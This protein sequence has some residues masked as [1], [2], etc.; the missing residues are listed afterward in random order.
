MLAASE[1]APEAVPELAPAPRS[2]GCETE[3][4]LVEGRPERWAVA[5]EAAA[6][7][8]P[9]PRTRNEG[10]AMTTALVARR[11]TRTTVRSQAQVPLNWLPIFRGARSGPQES[12]FRCSQRQDQPEW[13]SCESISGSQGRRWPVG[14]PGEPGSLVVR[15]VSVT[16]GGLAALDDVSMAVGDGEVVGVI[17]P[18]GAGK[19]TLFNVICG[20]VRPT[21]GTI[22]YR[23]TELRRH[24]PHDL[25]R[26]GIA[27]TLQGVGLWRGLSVAENVMAGAHAQQRADFA[28]AIFGLW[29]SSREQKRI[30]RRSME[31]LEELRISEFAN[32]YPDALP[33]A[34]QKRVALARALVA[35]PTLL[36]LD[37]PASGLSSSETDELREMIGV[38]RGRM[39]VLLV[40]HHMDL[41]MSTCDRLVVLNFGRVIASG[42]PAQVRAD[43][44]VTTAYLGEDVPASADS[45][46]QASRA[47]APDVSQLA[48][49]PRRADGAG[50]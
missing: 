33:Y 3:T 10:T 7:A 9:V 14:D 19:T 11:L 12:E 16:F 22:S 8:A 48:G 43:P 21:E 13:A 18:N 26:L 5:Y 36:M 29:R 46:T 47:A 2:L 39:G 30:R 44:E 34:I 50:G 41:V 24:H 49:G 23:G 20:F 42:P 4:E 6:T 32:W 17:G 37:E 38:L 45:A 40:E 25:A 35:E 28:S 31:V 15:E 27:R 1:A